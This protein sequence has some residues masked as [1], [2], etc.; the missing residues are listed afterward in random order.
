MIIYEGLL[1]HDFLEKL[2]KFIILSLSCFYGWFRCVDVQI[3]ALRVGSFFKFRLI[4][5][6]FPH[7]GC[8]TL[9]TWIKTTFKL[10]ELIFHLSLLIFKLFIL[11]FQLVK[12]I[13][14]FLV[15][16]F[17][18][19]PLIQLDSFLFFLS[20]IFIFFLVFSLNEMK[21][22]GIISIKMDMFIRMLTI[23]RFCETVYV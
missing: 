3:I 17:D 1:I 19:N 18:I 16:K 4:M 7:I 6:I 14:K 2:L 23:F 20:F 21:C 8:Y 12:I 9:H 5:N 15:F 10:C 11:T 13:F 22:W